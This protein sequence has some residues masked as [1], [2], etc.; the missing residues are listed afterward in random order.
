MKYIMSGHGSFYIR[1]GWLNKCFNK[2]FKRDIEYKV[3]LIYFSKNKQKKAIDDLG[4]GS[5]MVESMKYWLEILEVI[6]KDKTN[7]EL[8]EI[9]KVIFKKDEYLQNINSL[10]L[11]HSNIF[12]KEN[13]N[14]LIWNVAFNKNESNEFTKELLEN[15]VELFCKERNIKYSKKTL[16]DSVN[17]FI[18][19]YCKEADKVFNPEDNIV[20]PFSRLKCIEKTVDKLY[21]IRYIDP[22]EISEYLIYYLLIKKYRGYKG[23]VQLSLIEAYEYIYK[24]IR[25]SYLDFEKILEL[26]EGKNEIHIDRAVGLNIITI[27]VEKESEKEILNKIL[28]S[29]L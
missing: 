24:V 1:E 5:I 29:E 10:W 2:I 14:V 15:R 4:V 6:E 23:T 12:Y 21:K 17:V 8:S 3:P 20:S 28:G 11:L 16:Q 19:V 18:K 27:D 25:L 9:A 7:C 22:K 26:L 13:E